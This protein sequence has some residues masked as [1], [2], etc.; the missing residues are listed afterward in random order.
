MRTLHAWA[1]T[2]SAMRHLLAPPPL[3]ALSPTA[4]PNMVF[5]VFF[6]LGRKSLPCSRRAGSTCSVLCNPRDRTSRYLAR[7]AFRNKLLRLLGKGSLPHRHM[8]YRPWNGRTTA[9]KK[10]SSAHV[11]DEFCLAEQQT[12]MDSLQRGHGLWPM[13]GH[14]HAIYV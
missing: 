10:P 9:C 14:D 4:T 8:F 1:G 2:A 3:L 5:L 6:E 12:T 13:A 11:C 7:P